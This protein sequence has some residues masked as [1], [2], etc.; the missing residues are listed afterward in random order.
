MKN[1]YAAPYVRAYFGGKEITYPIESFKYT[2]AEDDDDNCEINIRTNN[3]KAPDERM[4]QEGAIW[5]VIWGFI[6]G[7]NSHKRLIVCYEIMWEFDDNLLLLT[8]SFHEKAISMKQRAVKDIHK[9]GNIVSILHDMGKTHGVK[10]SVIVPDD[11]GNEQKIDTTDEIAV[12]AQKLAEFNAQELARKRAAFG[13]TPVN[14]LELFTATGNAAAIPQGIGDAQAA[15]RFVNQFTFA[16]P[17]P[18][19][20]KT[21]KQLMDELGK[22]QPGGQYILDTTDDAAVLK[23]RNFNQKPHRAYTWAGGDGELQAFQPE[24]KGAGKE[25][26]SLNMQVDGWDRNNKTYFSGDVNVG[27]EDSLDDR[28]KETLAKFRKQAEDLKNVND[29]YIVGAFGTTLNQSV[30]ADNTRLG[31][32]FFVPI[33][34]IQKKDALQNTI[35]YFTNGGKNKP[36][37]DPTVNDPKAALANAANARQEAELKNNPGYF[38]AFGDPT[39][40]KGMIITILGV[41]KKYSGNYYITHCDHI[42]SGDKPYMIRCDIV[43]QGHNTKTNNAY[44]PLS[45]T[46]DQLNKYIG[47]QNA[48]EKKRQLSSFDPTKGQ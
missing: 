12:W 13:D 18:Q 21:D 46:T 37:N 47:E 42:I 27:N 6:G 40:Q 23:K 29:N 26:A 30:S 43:R 44:I 39:I 19:A 31:K 38:E 2:Y 5:N 4:F 7:Q 17:Y 24:S 16:S 8:I 35:D 33:L 9:S 3:R 45:Q 28:S 15:S 11:K 10:T 1:G 22:R 32:T 14:V 41:S 36:F 25:G 48:K 20:N 34:A